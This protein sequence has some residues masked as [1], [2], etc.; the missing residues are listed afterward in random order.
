MCLRYRSRERRSE[1]GKAFNKSRIRGIKDLVYEGLGESLSPQE[2]DRRRLPPRKEAANGV[3]FVDEEGWSQV[4]GKGKNV[5]YFISFYFFFPPLEYWNL[6]IPRQGE[7]NS[8][9]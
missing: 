7:L 6:D 1:T 2:I 3:V 9:C 4:A 5:E 8:R